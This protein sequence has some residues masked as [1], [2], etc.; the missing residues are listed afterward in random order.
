M[1]Q[2]GEVTGKMITIAVAGTSKIAKSFIRAAKS[3][4]DIKID[5]VYSR[6]MERAKVFA[7]DQGIARCFDDLEALANDRQIDAVYVAS[8]NAI[9]CRQVLLL[10]GHGKHV[11]CE[12]SLG[13]NSREVELMF[14]SAG[15]NGVILLEAMRS[16]HDPGYHQL[17]ENL[18]KLGEITE[19]EFWFGRYSSR[20]DDFKA[21]KL[22]NIFN[23]EY[24]AGALMDMGV[25]CVEP[26]AE[27][28]GMPPKI[29]AEAELI[30]GGIDGEGKIFA[31]YPDKKINLY[32]SKINDLK[33]ESVIY[34][35]K[36]TMV[37][38]DIAN[39]EKISITYSDGRKEIIRDAER[40]E[41]GNMRYEAQFFADAVQ[42]KSDVKHYQEVS[43]ITMK[44]MDEARKICGIVFPADEEK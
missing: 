36:G 6:S 40:V 5:A 21:G 35:S 24:S 19:A 12:K 25:Y 23:R 39:P 41:L 26:M 34:G 28:F 16:I 33:R 4:E 44:I 29:H 42:G 14:R 3:C 9:H 8:P 7:A 10:T 18:C 20:Y 38:D 15:T 43:E 30:R 11:L 2:Q 27:L 13:S 37:I 22:P 31:E 1:K 32:Y 17:K